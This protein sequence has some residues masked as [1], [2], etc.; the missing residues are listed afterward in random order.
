M[1]I[2]SLER[3]ERLNYMFGAALVLVVSALTPIHFTMGVAFGVVLSC[4]NFS[5]IR[6]L[7]S[8]LLAAKPDKRGPTAF[9]FVPKMAGVLGVVALAIYFLPIS[10]IGMGIGFSVFLVSIM[11]ESVRFMTGAALS[12]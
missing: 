9:F 11:V 6:R 10:A 4:V 3:I 1:D 2:K 7:V 12:Q 5:I 8:K